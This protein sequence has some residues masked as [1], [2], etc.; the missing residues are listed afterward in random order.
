M[1]QLDIRRIKYFHQSDITQTH[2]WNSIALRCS[3]WFSHC[4]IYLRH[5]QSLRGQN[6]SS[7]VKN[8]ID[9]EFQRPV[10]LQRPP[11]MKAS[12]FKKTWET[13]WAKKGRGTHTANQASA[14]LT[15]HSAWSLQSATEGPSASILVSHLNFC[16]DICISPGSWRASSSCFIPALR[17]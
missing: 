13:T 4:I 10:S 11:L 9:W 2:C 17:L 12:L 16:Q 1:A 14:T 5:L 15:L 3:Y 6:S 7:I 8:R